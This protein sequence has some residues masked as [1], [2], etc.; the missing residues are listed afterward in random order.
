MLESPSTLFFSDGLYTSWQNDK[1]DKNS[2]STSLRK[3]SRERLENSLEQAQQRLG[4]T[5]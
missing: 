3:A 2:V 1:H 4:S 5:K